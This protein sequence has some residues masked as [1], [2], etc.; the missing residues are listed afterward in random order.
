MRDLE[1]KLDVMYEEEEIQKRI[2]EVAKQI[3]K[4]Y[5]NEEIVIVSVL[6]GAIFFTVDL[7]KKMKTPINLEVMQVS[8]Y[9]GTESTGNIIVK[10]DLDR[11]IEGKNVLIVE[12]II[13]TGYT[14]KYLKEYLESKNP[15]SLKIA[16]LVNK[17]GRRKADVDIDYTCFNIDNKFVVGYGFDVDEYG[18]NIPF[19]GSMREE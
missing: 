10:K 12:D 15:K 16:V 13:D 14:L 1:S 4:D 17:E 3:D 2:K 6:K 18:R 7:V 11:D 9:N 19:I 8:S 5:E